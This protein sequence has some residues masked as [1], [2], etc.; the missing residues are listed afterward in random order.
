MR[1]TI[2]LLATMALTLLVA[3]GVALAVTK[4][5]T[6]GPDYLR[7]TNG[8]DNLI[9]KGGN[10]IL[11]S[12]AGDDDLLGGRGKDLVVGG[13]ACC[14][15]SDFSGGD[16]NL[17]GGPGND[18]VAGGLGSDNVVGGQGNDLVDGYTGSDKLVGG[19]GTDLITD[20]E[21]RGGATDTLIGGDGN[22]FLGPVNKPA[23][24]DILTCGDGFDRVWVDRKDVVAP[25]CEKVILGVGS[26][27]AEAFFG[28][29]P[30]SFFEG[31]PRF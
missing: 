31:L 25:D 10:D 18:A 17:L 13:K 9:G 24:K 4:I 27:Q 8:D 11:N 20:G 15:E 28:S 7:G 12:L 21:R 1:R 29:I 6:D 30:E 5:G 22:D 14:D 3:S 26:A 2:V 16:K 23:G 19:P